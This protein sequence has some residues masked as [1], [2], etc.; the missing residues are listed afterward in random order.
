MIPRTVRR[1]CPCTPAA[2]VGVGSVVDAVVVVIGGGVG[3]IS[4]DGAVADVGDGAVG[5][6]V[7][8]SV[9]S[10]CDI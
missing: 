3:G 5:V 4:G 9:F 10:S 7:V 1:Y 2:V 8:F 6:S